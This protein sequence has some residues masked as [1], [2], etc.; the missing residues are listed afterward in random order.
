MTE[1]WEVH[2]AVGI[3]PEAR[4]GALF[5]V[6]E[7]TRA[8]TVRQALDDPAGDRDWAVHALVDLAASDEEGRA[9]IELVSIAPAP[10]AG[11]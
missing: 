7:S 5:Q 10:P 3:G 11:E 2:D 1:Y 9:V 8:W 6:V 4:S